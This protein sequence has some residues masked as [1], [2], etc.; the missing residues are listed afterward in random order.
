MHLVLPCSPSGR[1]AHCQRSE[2]NGWEHT[3]SPFH[4]TLYAC[5][6]AYVV[7]FIIAM[8]FGG[9]SF[10][11]LHE[12]PLGGTSAGPLVRLGALERDRIAGSQHQWWRLLAAP[13]LVAGAL[14]RQLW[15]A[16]HYCPDWWG[17]GLPH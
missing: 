5:T 12:N 14:H 11:P 3:Y 6:A 1:R 10:V 15:T 13:F 16:L 17:G 4:V 8:W 7:L 2:A 9:W